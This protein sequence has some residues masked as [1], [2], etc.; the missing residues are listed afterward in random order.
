MAFVDG[1]VLTCSPLRILPA[2]RS[3]P[4][5]SPRH[6]PELHLPAIHSTLYKKVDCRLL[7]HLKDCRRCC[8]KVCNIS[9]ILCRGNCGPQRTK[10]QAPPVF[11]WPRGLLEGRCSRSERRGG[12]GD[13][14]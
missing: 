10:G 11:P 5:T 13:G 2:S 4:Q 3:I 9:K 1:S 8:L 14:V 7:C 12:F 6:D